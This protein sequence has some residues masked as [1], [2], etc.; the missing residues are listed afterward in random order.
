MFIKSILECKVIKKYAAL[1]IILLL[2]DMV[3]KSYQWCNATSTLYQI[4]NCTA[5]HRLR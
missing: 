1:Y 4:I 5:M 2:S 3:L